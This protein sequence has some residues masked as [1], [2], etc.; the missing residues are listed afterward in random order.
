MLHIVVSEE[1]FE[2]NGSIPDYCPRVDVDEPLGSNIFRII[3]MQPNYQFSLNEILTVSP[4]KGIC[5]LF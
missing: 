1:I 4:F 5:D 2:H 3:N